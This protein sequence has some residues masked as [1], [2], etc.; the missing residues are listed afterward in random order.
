MLTFIIDWPVVILIGLIFAYGIKGQPQGSVFFTRAF[1]AGKIILTLFVAIVYYSY[2]LAPD[3]M[4]GYYVR[5]SELPRWLVFYVLALYYI[6]Y[7]AGFF[8]AHEGRKWR[9][10]YPPV[11]MGLMVVGEAL[12]I[13]AQQPRYL[14]VG[15]YDQFMAGTTQLLS[16]SA[17]GTVPG[18]LS[19]VLIVLGLM[20]LLWSRRQSFA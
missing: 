7:A 18:I 6:A 16:D 5:D 15:T 1:V 20:A 11:V 13:M 10:W 14:A 8:I 19:G 17:V 4:W 3:W 12:L 2:W 9:T